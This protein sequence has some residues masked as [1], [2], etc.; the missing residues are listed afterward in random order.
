MNIEKKDTKLDNADRSNILFFLR[1]EEN[2]RIQAIAD[3]VKTLK[4]TY[5][6][7]AKDLVTR[8]NLKDETLEITEYKQISSYIKK[9]LRQV[10]IDENK[11][12][13]VDDCFDE[14]PEFKDHKYDKLTKGGSVNRSLENLD[15]DT[16]VLETLSPEK[17]K[18]V[19]RFYR[20]MKLKAEDVANEKGIAF[21]DKVED[22]P[23]FLIQK[24]MSDV[25]N[26][27]EDITDR[28]ADLTDN[29]NSKYKMD[30]RLSKMK[31]EEREEFTLFIRAFTLFQ[32]F[33]NDLLAS[34]T[35]LRYSFSLWKLSEL[36]AD[37][38]KMG[39]GY[40]REKHKIEMIDK[41]GVKTGQYRKVTV[42]GIKK[43]TPEVY[44]F[45]KKAVIGMKCYAWLTGQCE[46]DDIRVE[47]NEY[48]DKRDIARYGDTLKNLSRRL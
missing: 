3:S 24:A 20:T 2:Q 14:Y 40:A 45:M 32:D 42:K 48:L 23:G 4:A 9:K 1:K 26:E 46:L 39:Y 8:I 7:Y 31:P 10:G 11:I 36:V 44:E 34:C 19:I 43:M 37:V 13:Y 25:I 6:E 16:E 18:E 33:M 22:Q 27:S 15:L 47:L 38:E 17:L 28:L 21:V 35:D 29:W 41:N 5:I 12:H 30:E